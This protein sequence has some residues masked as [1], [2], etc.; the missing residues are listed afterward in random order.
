MDVYE[1]VSE[2]D[3]VTY[4]YL[5]HHEERMKHQ[6]NI[7]HNSLGEILDGLAEEKG[8]KS[9]RADYATLGNLFS[10]I[11][12]NYEERQ[13]YIR[14]GASQEKIDAIARLEKRL[15]AQLLITSHLLIADASGL[16]EEA[17]ARANEAQREASNLTVILM[18]VLAI[19]ITTSS[20]LITRS[21]SKPL[22]ELTKGVEIIG[23]GNLEHKVKVKTR[24]EIGALSAAFNKMTKNL[25]A[26]HDGLN[27]EITVRMQIEENLRKL[28]SG[29]EI[30]VA[31]RTKELN[32]KVQKLDKNQEAMLY[33]VEDL[34]TTSKELKEAKQEIEKWNKEL[35][36]K[37][38]DRTIELKN[39]IT[40]RKRKEEEL[41]ELQEN[42]E[43]LVKIRTADLESFSY[44]VSHDLRAPLRAINGFANILNEDFS[45]K[46]NSEGR[47][48]LNVIQNNT[49]KMA[50]LID[51]LLKFSHMG[52]RE[53]IFSN[54][55]MHELAESVLEEL[56][57]NE[58][59]RILHL[60]IEMI[61]K[62]Y[63]DRA[64]I[65]EVFANL[66]SNAL[67]FTRSK[68]DTRITIEGKEG[69]NENLYII[70]DN[71]VGFDMKYKDKL[72]GVFQRLH[73]IEDFEGTGVGLAIVKQIIDKHG[74]RVW[75]EGEVNGGAIFYFTLLKQQ[76]SPD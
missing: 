3:I 13:K 71:G 40:Q 65:K 43:K 41:R 47:R 35:E 10:Q 75:A 8:L 72:F 19:A 17:H 30:K 33:M 25:K 38:N 4:D 29:L 59:K 26:S 67:K 60:K 76:L 27:K 50:Q 73:S 46:L 11:T 28:K 68:D 69:K 7:K 15:V 14:E 70:K 63:G 39:E 36:K 44:S 5:L 45:N 55:N 31:E 48:I 51:D 6:W 74:G 37:V 54:I 56:R 9:I 21:I 53:L 24:D 16:A 32:E 12:A 20:L 52:R 66:L 18:I 34:N 2:L 22:E 64:M 62:S 1:S 49:E 58:S 23:N 42:L 57:T 61:P